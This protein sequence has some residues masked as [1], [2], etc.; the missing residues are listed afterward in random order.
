M[1]EIRKI[2]FCAVTA[3]LKE[4]KAPIEKILTILSES[5]GLN[6]DIMALDGEKV[7]LVAREM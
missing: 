3:S 2:V 7:T 1:E 5:V 6:K 4:F